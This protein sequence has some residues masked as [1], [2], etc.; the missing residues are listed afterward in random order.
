[1]NKYWAGAHTKHRLMYHLVWIP[2]YR[3]RL[4]EGL[5]KTR[6]EALFQ[7]C[8][9]INGWQIEELNLQPD[10]V[11]MLIRIKPSISVAKVVQFLKGGSS[12]IVRKEFPELKKFLWGDSFWSDGYFAE[13]CGTVNE[14]AIRRYIQKQSKNNIQATAFKP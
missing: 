12:K 2:K 13:T 5:L 10:H 9:E 7:E 11:H 3:K 1:M 8:A 6:L 14:Q 4:L